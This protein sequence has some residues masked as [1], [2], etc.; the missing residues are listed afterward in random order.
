MIYTSKLSFSICI[1]NAGVPQ[2]EGQNTFDISKIS[3]YQNFDISIFRYI[4]TSTFRYRYIET[5]IFMADVVTVFCFFRSCFASG[6]PQRGNEQ[7]TFKEP[8][9]IALRKITRGVGTNSTSGTKY[10]C[11][12]GLPQYTTAASL[13]SHTCVLHCMFRYQSDR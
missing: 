2:D 10:F 11:R 13:E 1:K 4:E 12:T 8:S 3:T 6:S 7:N 9:I 5:S